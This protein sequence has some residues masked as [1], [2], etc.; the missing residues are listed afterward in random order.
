MK[1]VGVGR[2]KADAQL[3]EVQASIEP[4]AQVTRPA[5]A[6]SFR[7]SCFILVHFF[8][9]QCLLG[10]HLKWLLVVQALK[11]LSLSFLVHTAYDPRMHRGSESSNKLLNE[12]PTELSSRSCTCSSTA[13]FSL[14]C[15]SESSRFNPLSRQEHLY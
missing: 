6:E 10:A 2:C 1:Q 9:S 8:I 4:E 12:P 3:I 7:K 13:D 14:K 15:R 5:R 11:L